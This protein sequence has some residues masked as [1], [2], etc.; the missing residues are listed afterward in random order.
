MDWAGSRRARCAVLHRAAGAAPARWP[1]DARRR[2]PPHRRP[3]AE[4]QV[5]RVAGLARRARDAVLAENTPGAA[6]HVIERESA[7]P[8]A[9]EM[10]GRVAAQGRVPQAAHHEDQIPNVL[11]PVTIEV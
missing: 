5:A 10:C 11:A 7:V 3:E 9:V 2:G 1:R 6:Q 8:V 4:L